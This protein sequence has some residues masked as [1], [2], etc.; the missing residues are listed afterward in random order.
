[1]HPDELEEVNQLN[2]TVL[3]CLC[4]VYALIMSSS[5]V[6]Y[7]V[8][9]CIVLAV[10]CSPMIAYDLVLDKTFIAT[11]V[12]QVIALLVVAW[13]IH[14]IRNGIVFFKQ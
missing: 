3:I 14:M 9:Q 10:G 1:L 13:S 12:G 6:E 7:Y 8:F 11:L 2:H 4:L 5:N